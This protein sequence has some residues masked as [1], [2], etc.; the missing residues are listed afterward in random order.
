MHIWHLRV[1]HCLLI[2]LKLNT[3]NKLVIDLLDGDLI[4]LMLVKILASQTDSEQEGSDK[5]LLG[6]CY[7]KENSCPAHVVQWQT[8]WAPCALQ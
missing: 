1:Y 3:N 7:Q 2:V 4:P 6:H 5:L 8:T